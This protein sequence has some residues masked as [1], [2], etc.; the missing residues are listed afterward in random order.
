H[1]VF[2]PKLTDVI[3][4]YTELAGR[5]PLPPPWAFGAWISSDIWRTGGE[6]RYAVTK[7]RELKIPVSA[8]VFDSPWEVAYNDFEFNETQ[9]AN[10]ATL[11][12]QTFSGFHKTADMMSFFQQHGLKVICWMSPFVN[13]HSN[14][15]S[16]PGQNVGKARNYTEGEARN[17]FVRNLPD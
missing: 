15:E 3:T 11:E 13:I 5:P 1:V 7:F 10:P 17:L 4:R 14:D 16:V 12:N 8:F 6:V 2:G 9:F